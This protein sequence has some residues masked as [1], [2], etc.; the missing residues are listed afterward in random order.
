MT[1]VFPVI[2]KRE[3]LEAL[4]DVVSVEEACLVLGTFEFAAESQLCL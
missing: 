1:L 2:L 3:S 4:D